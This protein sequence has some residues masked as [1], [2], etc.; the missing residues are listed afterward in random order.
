M[1]RIDSIVV[2]IATAA[3]VAIALALVKLPISILPPGVVS[4]S[5]ASDPGEP[6]RS[7][8]GNWYAAYYA[9]RYPGVQ[10]EFEVD[11]FFVTSNVYCAIL[12]FFLLKS[13]VQR[14][15]VWCLAILGFL[16]CLYSVA[17]L[18]F[19]VMNADP[20][21][22]YVY[23]MTFEEKIHAYVIPLSIAASITLVLR[24]TLPRDTSAPTN[25][26]RKCPTAS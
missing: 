23:Y 24:L 4:L 6:P 7:L 8:F 18:A 9:A 25:I 14:L 20:G 17:G 2:G 10:C 1:T 15:A 13:Q 11:I 19:I 21:N 12:A 26:P 3:F 16:L 5:R 22:T